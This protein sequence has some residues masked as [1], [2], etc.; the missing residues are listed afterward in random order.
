MGRKSQWAIRSL[1]CPEE[2]LT[3]DLLVEWKVEKGKR[4]LQSVCCNH[5]ELVDYSG[6]E[7]Q[8]VCLQK[9]ANKKK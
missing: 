4:I 6:K 7:C 5:P 3:V 2:D 9:L 1:K 8:W